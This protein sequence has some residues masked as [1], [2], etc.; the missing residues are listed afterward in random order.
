MKK[1]LIIALILIMIP[2]ALCAKNFSF[3]IGAAAT[4]GYTINSIINQESIDFTSFRYGLYTNLKLTL[5]SLN[6]TLFPT[7]I[8]GEPTTIFGDISANF[9]IDVSVLRLQAGLSVFYHGLT[10]LKNQFKFE[11]EGGEILEAPLSLRAEID[12]IFG[13]LNI[14]AWGVLPTQATLKTL[15]KI[16]EI[17]DFWKDT[18]LGL[19]L[20]FC[21]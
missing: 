17:K 1:V 8:S 2:A 9:A 6:A 5:L 19:S 14:G 10:D 3:G 21:F 11:F 13:E 4:N 12:L 7:F 20:G 15:D 16:V 18:I